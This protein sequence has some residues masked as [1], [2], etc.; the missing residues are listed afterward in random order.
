MNSPKKIRS[1]VEFYLQKN[2]TFSIGETPFSPSLDLPLLE[3][4]AGGLRA[5]AGAGRDE[6]GLAAPLPHCFSWSLSLEGKEM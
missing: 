3:A 5:A 6:E 4:A 2:L 1:R